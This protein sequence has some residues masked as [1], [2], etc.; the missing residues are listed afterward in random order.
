[1]E[2]GRGTDL[3]R[4]GAH[5]DHWYPLAPSGRVKPGRA[6]GASF[7][8]EPIVLARSESGSLF[9]LENRCAHRQVPLDVG[10][11]CGETLR[12]GYHGWTYDKSGRC[13]DV[14]YLSKERERPNGVRGYP[15]REAYGLIFVFPGEPAKAAATPL[16]DVPNQADPGYKTRLLDRRIRCHYSFMHENLMDM[17]HQFLHR[18]L[19]GGIRT[20]LLDLRRG[21]DWIEAAYTFSRVSGKRS[22]GEKFMIGAP[23]EAA[24]RGGHDLMLIRTQYPYQT[25]SFTRPGRPKPALDLWMAYVPLGAEQKSTQIFGLMMIRRPP[26]PG[27][28][29]LFWPFI[30]YFT[31]GIF[32]QDQ[33]IMELEQKAYDA[34]GADWNREVFPLIR[35]LRELLGGRGRPA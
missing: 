5:P 22:L 7:A 29:H 1:M 34:Q 15:C 2:P 4:T 25:L 19:M 8:G 17:N 30:V 14:P 18:R 27:L 13:V 26:V 23:G 6:L 12:C 3:R 35:E 9:A 33:R 10:V 24:D 32:D 20:T 28:I 21:E 31:N 11:V 16:P